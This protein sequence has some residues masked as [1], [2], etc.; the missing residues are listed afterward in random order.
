LT[1]N[2]GDANIYFFAENKR[3]RKCEW[4]FMAKKHIFAIPR[5]KTSKGID[6]VP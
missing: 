1:I 3:V 4:Y 6:K 2:H 5:Y